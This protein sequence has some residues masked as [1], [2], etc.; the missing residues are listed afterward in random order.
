MSKVKIAGHASGSGTLTIQAPNTSSSRTIT[1]PDATTTLVGTDATQTLTNKTLTS[2]TTSGTINAGA[3]GIISSSSG[4]MQVTAEDSLY[5]NFDSDN[6]GGESLVIRKGTTDRMKV[7]N[8]GYTNISVTDTI[9]SNEAVLHL[10]NDNN[11]VT[12]MVDSAKSSS[13]TDN[14]VKIQSSQ[15]TADSSY[16]MLEVRNG[17]GARLQILD[18]GNII[19]TNNSYGAISDER[20]KQD[21]TDASSQWDDIKNLIIRKFKLKREVNKDGESA[22][23]Q[24]GVVAQELEN[25]GMSKLVTEEVPDK[26]DVV[27]HS[28]FGTIDGDGLFIEGEKVKAVK[29]SVLYMKSIK[30]LQEAMDRIETLE[31][32]VTALE[33]E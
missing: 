14:V 6:G 11:D 13:Y 33:N 3:D 19:N 12:L 22:P 30:A 27:L 4:Y 8:N 18:S 21:I 32:K 24:I 26:E 1:L 23:Y 29:Y 15:D 2:P 9:P 25:A 5:L 28:D 7:A 31:T 16:K 10:S 20:I 17:G